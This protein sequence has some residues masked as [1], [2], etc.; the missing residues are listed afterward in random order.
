MAESAELAELRLL[1]VAM[2]ARL[3]RQHRQIVKLRTKL[4]NLDDEVGE[5]LDQFE[6]TEITDDDDYLTYEEGDSEAW[7][8]G[9]NE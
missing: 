5:L 8:H 7:K 1:V 2:D 6:P 3:T 4:R 9:A